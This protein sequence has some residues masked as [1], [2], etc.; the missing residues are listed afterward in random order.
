MFWERAMSETF[1]DLSVAQLDDLI[2][3]ASKVRQETRERRRKELKAEIEGKL[4]RE[5]FTVA[6]VLGPA[7]KAETLPA[8]YADGSGRTWS[9]KGRM[10]QWLQQRIDAGEQ[11]ESFRIVTNGTT[12]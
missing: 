9:G 7:R 6:E 8:K 11:L 2:A 4:K 10:P 12:R 3:E 5:G 1:K